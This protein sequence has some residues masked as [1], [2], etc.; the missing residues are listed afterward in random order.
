MLVGYLV[1]DVSY[2]VVQIAGL[3]IAMRV[4]Y[5]VSDF[6]IVLCV[7]CPV[8]CV[9]VVRVYSVSLCFVLRSVCWASEG[10]T[11]KTADRP[12]N[13][14]IFSMGFNT[15]LTLKTDSPVLGTKHLESV[16]F[17]P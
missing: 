3:F 13:T 15:I 5:A 10:I 1:W 6:F 16:W 4:A 11:A 8:S 14:I 17:A 7:A 2:V 12:L 9:C